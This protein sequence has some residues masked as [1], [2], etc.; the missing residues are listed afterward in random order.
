M[1]TKLDSRQMRTQLIKTK[2]APKRLFRVAKLTAY[3]HCEGTNLANTVPAVPPVCPC[4]AE[5]VA[6]AD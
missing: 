3:L 1:S 5:V 2:K 4:A 6:V